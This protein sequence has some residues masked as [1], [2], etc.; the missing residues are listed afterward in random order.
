MHTKKEV[1]VGRLITAVEIQDS[2]SE[3][4]DSDDV[5][6]SSSEESAGPDPIQRGDYNRGLIIHAPYPPQLRRTRNCPPRAGLTFVPGEA[7]NCQNFN[8]DACVQI[9][10]FQVITDNLRPGREISFEAEMQRAAI[11]VCG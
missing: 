5:N 3:I 1:K 2:N 4:A 10:N 7:C 8:F 6:T 11:A 9:D